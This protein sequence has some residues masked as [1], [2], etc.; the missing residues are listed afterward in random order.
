MK[1]K[2]CAALVAAVTGGLLLCSSGSRAWADA[3][4]YP[5]AGVVNPAVY[6]FTASS[7]GDII[8]YF[9]RIEGSGPVWT[10]LLGLQVN[11]VPTGFF[12]L[13]N[14]TSAVGDSFNLG[15]ANAGDVLTFVLR[16]VSL[17][18]DA[19][20]NPALNAAYDGGAGIQHVYSTPYTAT[21]PVF[22]SI[23]VGTFVSWEDIPAEFGPNFD[24]NDLSFVFTSGSVPGPIV[25]AGLP[26]LILASVG[27]L[28]WWRRR[29]KSPELPTQRSRFVST[30]S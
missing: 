30:H 4:P 24:Y 7:T 14:Q 18:R 25:G 13:N 27:L 16:N 23:P 28:G 3:I 8:A 15:H 26:G 11:D 1:S 10:S 5:T 6:T 12:G 2:L 19:F 29:G 21:F 17:G 9:V 20:S 22:S